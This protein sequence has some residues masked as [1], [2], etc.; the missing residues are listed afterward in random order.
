MVAR[1]SV[2]RDRWDAKTGRR[3]TYQGIYFQ[4]GEALSLPEAE[5][6]PRVRSLLTKRYKCAE[7]ASFPDLIIRDSLDQLAAM[8]PSHDGPLKPTVKAMFRNSYASFKNLKEAFEQKK[9]QG[10]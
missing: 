5:F 3:L 1:L 6:Q 7:P 8:I 9:L 2:L 10:A 4:V